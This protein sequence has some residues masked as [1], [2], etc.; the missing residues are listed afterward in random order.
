MKLDHGGQRLV[1]SGGSPAYDRGLSFDIGF[2]SLWAT[3]YVTKEDFD[4]F[5]IRAAEKKIR[6]YGRAG[7]LL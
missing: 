3:D 7:V 1:D 6:K 2:L 4:R 5:S